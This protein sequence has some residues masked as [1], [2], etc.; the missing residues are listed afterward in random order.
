M[1]NIGVG[2]EK[3]S[4]LNLHMDD[5]SS[6]MDQALHVVP[7]KRVS[8]FLQERGNAR[9][10]NAADPL[11]HKDNE[12]CYH[13]ED[14]IIYNKTTCCNNKCVNL[15]EDKQNCGAC[16]NKCKFTQACCRGECVY[17][18]LDKRHC[19]RCNN[20]CPTGEFCVYGMCDYA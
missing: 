19:G 17:L 1:R 9:N 4:A 11:C 16:K 18:S 8:R 15:E 7:S 2:E 3:S 6:S 12:L 14:G 10:P 13:I 5:S 20:R